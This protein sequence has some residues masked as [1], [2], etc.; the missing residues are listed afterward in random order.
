N[1][2][3]VAQF[4]TEQFRYE[5]YGLNA[6]SYTLGVRGRNENGMKGAE[7]Q[8][9]LVIG[10]PMAPDSVQWIPGPL[11][12]TLVP[13][14]SVTATTDTSFEYWY[15]GETPIPLT[16][17]IEDNTQFLGRGNQW[18]IQNLKF[19]HTYYVYVRT[20]N[21]FGV[22]EFV[23]ASGKQTED[24]SDITDAILDEIKDS[25][26][27]KDIIENAVE[28]SKTVADLATAITQ[29]ADQLAAAVGANR[30][31]AEAIIGNALAIADVVV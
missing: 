22:S 14:M 15:A 6:G 19:D 23:E 9:S 13:V 8:V 3:V 20:R 24:Y 26:L 12:A 25:T 27:F 18:T 1:G 11:Q 4:E 5:F 28:T 30:Q 17:D 31:T 21:A 2:A 16:N 7:T 10:A 29:N